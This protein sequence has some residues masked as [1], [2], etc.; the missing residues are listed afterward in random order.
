[1]SSC[2]I[3]AA[4]S[5]CTAAVTSGVTLAKAAGD[6]GLTLLA[7]VPL[8]RGQTPG[9]T[10][11]PALVSKLFAAKPGEIVTSSEETGAYAAQLKEIQSPETV[12]DAEAAK[13]SDQLAGEARGDIAGAFTEALRKRFPVEIQ[14]EALDRM[15]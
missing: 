11:P 8:S 14:R 7:A 9:Q 6:K 13:L 4:I 2:E 15:F 12:P 3:C 5:S 10:T 1:M